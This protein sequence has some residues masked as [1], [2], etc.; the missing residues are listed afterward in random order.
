MALY[1]YTI[2]SNCT[3]PSLF[4]LFAYKIY[5]I[6][7]VL[8]YFSNISIIICCLFYGSNVVTNIKIYYLYAFL[9]GDNRMHVHAQCA[10]TH[11]HSSCDEQTFCCKPRFVTLPTVF[12]TELQ[13]KSVF[14]MTT[15]RIYNFVRFKRN[16][17]LTISALEIWFICLSD[18]GA[19]WNIRPQLRWVISFYR[20]KFCIIQWLD[21][22]F[23]S[24]ARYQST[25]HRTTN[26]I[27]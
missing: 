27:I 22:V 11:T 23:F 24:T 4:T 10:S 7:D 5:R 18:N 8:H 3:R 19:K 12:V 20:N 25:R 21:A 15:I 16:G 13:E 14:I 2:T 9:N 26:E 6:T 17:A 1:L